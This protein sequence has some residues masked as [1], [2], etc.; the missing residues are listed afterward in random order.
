MRR[1]EGTGDIAWGDGQTPR[2]QALHLMQLPSTYYSYWANGVRAQSP[3]AC[4]SWPFNI[5]LSLLDP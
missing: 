2:D 1:W 3:G 4:P 5:L